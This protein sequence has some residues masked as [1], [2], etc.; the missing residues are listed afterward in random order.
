MKERRQEPDLIKACEINP[1]AMMFVNISDMKDQFQIMFD[2]FLPSIRVSHTLSVRDV[3]V[4]NMVSNSTQPQELSSKIFICGVAKPYRQIIACPTRE[5]RHSDRFLERC[6]SESS[7]SY[8]KQS[9]TCNVGLIERPTTISSSDIS[10]KSFIP[11]LTLKDVVSVKSGYICRE[12]IIGKKYKHCWEN[13]LQE[14]EDISYL[15][16]RMYSRHGWLSK[17]SIMRLKRT[18]HATN[19]TGY[20]PNLQKYELNAEQMENDKGA[21]FLIQPM[22]MTQQSKRE[23]IGIILLLLHF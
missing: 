12:K 9:M 3:I 21:Q 23:I 1:D 16:E 20:K 13:G 7:M 17:A 15:A 8:H 14:S 10:R 11:Q 22:T 6:Q 2:R 4:N 18:P 19:C 5:N